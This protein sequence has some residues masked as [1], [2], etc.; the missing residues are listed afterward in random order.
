MTKCRANTMSRPYTKKSEYWEKRKNQSVAAIQPAPAPVLAR[1]KI[2][3]IEYD[4][5]TAEEDSLE[6][7]I[8]KAS[9]LGGVAR[10]GESAYG[11]KTEYRTK[12]AY[13]YTQI[14]TLPLP[15]NYLDNGSVD[16]TVAIELVHKC[17]ANIGIAKN[18][19]DIMAE[20]ANTPHRL[21]GGTEKSRRFVELWLKKIKIDHIKEQFFS[22]CFRSGNIFFYK[23][24]GDWNAKSFA[25]TFSDIPSKAEPLK[26]PLKYVLLNPAAIVK[27]NAVT[28]EYTFSQKFSDYELNKL[29]NPQTDKER[30]LFKS[31]EAQI[32]TLDHGSILLEDWRIAFAFYNKQDYEPFAL[33]FL[34]PALDDINLKLEMK[35][36]DQQV[37]RIVNNIILLLTNGAE[38]DK[39]GVNVQNIATLQRLFQNE[40]CGKT[41]VSDYTTKGEFLIPDLKKVIYPEKYTIVNE[42]IKEALSN[43]LF[44]TDAKYGNLVVKV[45]TFLKKMQKAR[46]R[47][48]EMMQREIDIA[49]EYMGLI[50]PPSIKTDKESLEDPA[51]IQKTAIRLLELG[52]I[53]P[54]DAIPLLKN[55]EYQ[56][57]ASLQSK[58]KDYLKQ[59]EDGLYMPLT[60]Q[61]MY[62]N[63]LVG[64]GAAAPTKP[65]GKKG[66]P[67]QKGMASENITTIEGWKEALKAKAKLEDMVFKAFGS[68]AQSDAEQKTVLKELSDKIFRSTK[69]S[70]WD[71]TLSSI[72]ENPE[73]ADEIIA[74]P[75]IIE[76]SMANNIDLQD[77]A[78]MKLAI[79]KSQELFLKT[80]KDV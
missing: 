36:R 50:N 30:Q 17:Y 43:I 4:F 79:N 78:L 68:T 73:K 45:Q 39:G 42:D 47:F 25:A 65:A 57:A 15:Y 10:S 64:G 37:L 77:A 70:E 51:I 38:P 31:I 71:T 13:K 46:A 28:S 67:K 33:P 8:S 21:E 61:P 24:T 59:R 44:G 80:A 72:V 69:E 12:S 7:T 60:G 27:N 66:R 54:E 56:D 48:E 9:R 32:P 23:L 55:R 52:V 75:D 29:K 11:N 76:L 22:E 40:A 62:D 6:K 26:L 63:D 35:R 2:G 58:Q 53:T 49:C 41:L 3:N 19:V 14:D 18:S 1:E 5:S 34:W 20:I 74:S 16:I